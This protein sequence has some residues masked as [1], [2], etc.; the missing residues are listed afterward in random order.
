MERDHLFGVPRCF[1]LDYLLFN[2]FLC[3]LFFVMRVTD[4]AS[5]RDDNTPCLTVATL[6][7]VI[8]TLEKDFAALF[9]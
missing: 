7:D 2:M 6:E 8:K 4:F 1:I 3:D 9:Q 5:Y